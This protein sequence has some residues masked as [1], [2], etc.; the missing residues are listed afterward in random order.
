MTHGIIYA[1]TIACLLLLAYFIQKSG[2]KPECGIYKFNKVFISMTYFGVLFVVG[3][4]IY[5]VYEETTDHGQHADIFSVFLGLS[6][7]LLLFIF[8]AIYYP[9]VRFTIANSTLTYRSIVATK[10][11]DLTRPF[12]LTCYDN[13]GQYVI[14]QGRMKTKITNYISGWEFLLEEIEQQSTAME[15]IE[16]K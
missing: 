4:I 3:L 16:K 14:Q 7:F 13:S 9:S 5:G 15:K 11:F 6:A 10:V 1:A 12:T 2:S 8:A